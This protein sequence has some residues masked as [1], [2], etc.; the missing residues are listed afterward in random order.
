[1]VL[2]RLG[3]RFRGYFVA[4][5]SL[6]SLLFTLTVSVQKGDSVLAGSEKGDSLQA[7]AEAALGRIE[8]NDVG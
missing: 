8:R 3:R 4:L 2:Q 5:L 7:K 6:G 1:M